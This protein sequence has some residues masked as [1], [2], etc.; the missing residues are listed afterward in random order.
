[1]SQSAAG[2]DDEPLEVLLID[3]T[4]LGMVRA[5]VRMLTRMLGLDHDRVEDLVL[6][7]HEIAVA[8]FAAD[9]RPTLLRVIAAPGQVICEFR[10]SEAGASPARTSPAQLHRLTDPAMNP[11]R[12][13]RLA[14]AL[15][16]EV[17][18]RSTDGTTVRVT[19]HLAPA[20]PQANASGQSQ[21]GD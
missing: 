9:S 7:V 18:R 20:Q 14:S 12:G 8:A 1:M 3:S 11:G 5:R 16:D 13:W 2:W 19:M 21:R 6:A 10:D 15:C 4:D 17:T